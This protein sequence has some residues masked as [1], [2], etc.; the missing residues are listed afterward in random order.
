MY[1]RY[2]TR[3]TAIKRPETADNTVLGFLR[4]YFNKWLININSFQLCYF[5][6][7]F[8]HSPIQI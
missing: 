2:V 5:K 6:D 7:K 3:N 4:K 8:I 1:Q